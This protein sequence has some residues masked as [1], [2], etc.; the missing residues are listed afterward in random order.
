MIASGWARIFRVQKDK[1]YINLTVPWRVNAVEG[2]ETALVNDVV[3]DGKKDIG[4]I[5]ASVNSL[6]RLADEL[7][8]YRAEHNLLHRLPVC[9]DV[10]NAVLLLFLWFGVELIVTTFLLRESGGLAM[11]F[12]ISTIYCFLNC[13]FPF[14][15]APY[16]RW[17]NYGAGYLGRKVGGWTLFLAVLGIGIWLNLLMGHYRS[18]ALELA[19]ID[20]AGADLEA[21]QIL[22]ERVSNTGVTAWANLLETP[23]GITD[24]F[25]W[26]LAVAGL[27]AFAL[28]FREGFVRDDV[29]PD[30][31]A[32]YQRFE[33]QRQSYDDDVE[34]LIDLLKTRRERGVNSIEDKKRQLVEDLGRIPQL[35]QQIKVLKNK[36][37]CACSALNSDFAELIDE[38]RR[39]NRRFRPSPEPQYFNQ[40]VRLR[41]HRPENLDIVLEPTEEQA[42]M[43]VDKLSQFSN[44]L[45]GEFNTLTARVRPSSDILL[46]DPLQ[47]SPGAG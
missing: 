10:W 5:D 12:I 25:S 44:R 46:V 4:P 11:V 2:E 13:L 41:E 6:K 18:A 42:K 32:L 14:L 19:A 35:N 9:H 3:A 34:K 36:F 40:A 16:S 45:H 27:V 15:V 23:L 39:E 33:D 26:M 7:R 8:R 24:T 22:V 43:M 30:Y 29:Y 20:Y 21:L 47:I 17:I 38:Y 37:E 28:S 1:N 31:G